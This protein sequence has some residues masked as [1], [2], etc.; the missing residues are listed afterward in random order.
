MR[1]TLLTCAWLLL[2][3]TG[4]FADDY[5]NE[6]SKNRINQLCEIYNADLNDSLIHQAPRDMQFHKEQN[7]WEHYYETWSLLVNTYI[8][9]GQVNT[10]LQ[11]VKLM[12]Q[13]A[14]ERNDPYGLALANYAMGNAYNNMGQLDEA[15]SCYDQSLALI[16]EADLET[17]VVNDI[18]SYYCDVLKEQKRYQEMGV[19]TEKWKKAIDELVERQSKKEGKQLNGGVWNSYYYLACAQ[20]NLGLGNLDEAEKAI[21]EAEKSN[22]DKSEF[23]PMS[24]TYYRAQLWLQRRNYQ[25][26][27]DYN[28]QRLEKSRQYDDK[29]SEVL[30][31]LQRAEIMKGLGVYKEAADMYQSVYEL[32][33]SIYKKDART[34]INELNTLF[35]VNEMEME[36]RLSRNR[37]VAVIAIII[38]LALALLLGYGS[39]MNLRLRRKN[40]ELAI[41]HAQAEESLRMKSDFIKN[42]SH[43]IRTPL[44]ILSGFSQVLAQQNADL[45]QEVRQEA[46]VNIQQNTNRITSLINRL[47]A[48]SESS[49]RSLIER[50]DTISAEQL[51]QTAI[52]GSG[53]A[54]DKRHQFS[55]SSTLGEGLTIVT[56][57]KYASQAICHLLD[58]AM[59]FTPEGGSISMSCR[60]EGNVLAI[61]IEDNGNGVPKEKAEEIFD[62]FVQLDTFKDGVGI[63]LSLSR[64]IV[65]QL[66]GDLV[67]DTNYQ[68][69]ARFVLTLPL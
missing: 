33:D 13:D 5:D 1:K 8:F 41:A 25:K 9:M 63:G 43:E 69:G 36:K 62:E 51:C 17:T 29:S 30:I 46:S 42:I 31:Y 10:G 35:R 20:M 7:C 38:A 59:K 21:D 50:T 67:L 48:L 18:F 49:S 60:T 45:P 14:A 47:L 15:I 65:R 64:N 12:H 34:Q 19:I 11:E 24:V 66:G 22:R 40:E 3:A 6:E 26:A 52:A 27:L 28:T 23:I 68:K 55:F 44:N 53:V 58:N 16:E 4:V 37:S 32:T 39:W 2:A 61:S 56:S 57:E 54:D